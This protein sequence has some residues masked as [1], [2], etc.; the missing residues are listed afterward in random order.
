M[1][2]LEFLLALRGLHAVD[3]F[4]EVRQ[5]FVAL[6]GFL[7]GDLDCL[8]GGCFL[9]A[10]LDVTAVVEHAQEHVGTESKHG[11]SLLDGV[12]QRLL[13]RLA[14]YQHAVLALV[15]VARTA[16]LLNLAALAVQHEP[17]RN[18]D[19]VVYLEPQALAL[20]AFAYENFVTLVESLFGDVP[21][22]AYACR[23]EHFGGLHDHRRSAK[24]GDVLSA[25]VGF[26]GVLRV[27]LIDL[28]PY[29]HV[30]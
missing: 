26:L 9:V 3:Y 5:T 30:V 22:E 24:A 4:L 16:V 23:A 13:G 1:S 12:G 27:G 7:F 8:L 18:F 6:L 15:L 17:E 11:Q 10:P 2:A 29:L 25:D 19:G 28:T 21:T 20:F 14:V